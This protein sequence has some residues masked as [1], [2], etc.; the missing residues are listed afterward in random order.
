[1]SSPLHKFLF[2]PPPSPPLAV[3]ATDPNVTFTPLGSSKKAAATGQ[4]DTFKLSAP[5]QT[6]RS[7]NQT[8]GHAINI[9]VEAANAY[10]VSKE[11]S[12]PILSRILSPRLRVLQ[13]HYI[14]RPLFRLLSFVI[15]LFGAAMLLS[16]VILPTVFPLQEVVTAPS[17]K[18]AARAPASAQ[19]API[20]RNKE[21]II[22]HPQVAANPRAF[23]PEAHPLPETH[24]LHALQSFIL[25]SPANHLPD[26]MDA[27]APIDAARIIGTR[28]ASRLRGKGSPQEQTWL[29]EL[30]TEAA[31][32][33][34]LWFAS[35]TPPHYSLEGIISRHGQ[36]RR[37]DLISLS[38]RP[39]GK[40][41]RDVLKR[42]GHDVEKVPVL[43]IGGEVFDASV[44]RMAELR[45]SGQLAQKLAQIGWR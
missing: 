20:A 14:P 16:H 17:P 41:V 40:T 29:N 18:V 23:R 4:A 24:E 10:E 19:V 30:V 35:S 25:E 9:D 22:Y 13:A 28:A 8:G 31:D 42:L 38:K 15:V 34:V 36:G 5:Q 12:R 7:R 2:S 45:S 32:K 26:D 33:V 43:V 3:G 1:M 44:E 27:S 39:D 21:P 37:P 11:S 6:N